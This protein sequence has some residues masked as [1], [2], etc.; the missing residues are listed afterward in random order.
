MILTGEIPKLDIPDV[1]RNHIL[2]FFLV[3]VRKIISEQDIYLDSLFELIYKRIAKEGAK[4]GVKVST[5]QQLLDNTK[6][7]IL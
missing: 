2:K 4:V 1:G 6:N 7:V 3:P 5:S